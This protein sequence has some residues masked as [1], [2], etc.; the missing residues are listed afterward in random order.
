MP[1]ILGAQSATA[2]TF[3]IDNS[4]RF[5]GSDS[6]LQ[7]TTSSDA[8]TLATKATFSIWI[9]N[10]RDG[11]DNYVSYTAGAVSPY[12]QFRF[13]DGNDSIW[14]QDY[15]GGDTY[16]V[17]STS[18]YRD[19]AAWYHLVYSYD[20]TPATPSA[21]SIRI[22]INGVQVTAFGTETYPSQNR[23][24]AMTLASKT[25]PIG[26]GVP[27]VGFYSGYFA[28]VVCVDG[29]ALLPT[30]FGQFNEDSPSIWEPIDVTGIT[31]GN[32]GFHLD[33]KD[34]SNLGNDVGG[35]IDFTSTNLA[36]INQ[37]TDT[38]TNNFCTMNPLDNY[39]PGST[40]TD[41]AL[42]VVTGNSPTTFNT[43]T[44]GLSAGKWYWE[45]KNVVSSSG[46]SNL[47]GIAGIP[48]DATGNY[49]GEDAYQW[50]YYGGDGNVYTGG[51][52]SSY[53]TAYANGD[54]V[55]VYL[56]LDNDKLYTAENGVI[57]NSGTGVSIT[58]VA[59]YTKCRF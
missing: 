37:C 25:F 52:S 31:L 1:L 41:G 23:A 16:Y 35:G 24:T 2:G 9:K 56:D 33:F 20:S 43:G 19:P 8:P 26:T 13:G 7:K 48:S 47:I 42:N 39:F 40:F 18:E 15:D 45:V 58:A 55:G 4:C 30:S 38:P 12:W 5:N 51:V 34:S 59:R 53:G 36:A 28:E 49:L 57:N 17:I 29:Q 46:N 21:S 10:V 27:G 22:F 6:K 3:S 50:G 32:Q 44:V 14:M 11:T 54:V